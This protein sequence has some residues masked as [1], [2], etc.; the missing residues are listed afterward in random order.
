MKKPAGRARRVFNSRLF[1][2][3]DAIRAATAGY[4]DLVVVANDGVDGGNGV[5]VAE[6]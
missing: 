4:R 5:D 1:R 3:R 6:A 2:R